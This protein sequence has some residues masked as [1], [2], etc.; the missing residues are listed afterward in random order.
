MRKRVLRLR[1]RPRETRARSGGLAPHALV[2]P[3]RN[4]AARLIGRNRRNAGDLETS[5]SACPKGHYPELGTDIPFEGY[6][7]LTIEFSVDAA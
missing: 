3:L 2:L 5:S 6:L 4:H 7:W 1:M